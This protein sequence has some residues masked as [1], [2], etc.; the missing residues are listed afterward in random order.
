LSI[1]RLGNGESQ[2]PDPILDVQD[3]IHVEIIHNIIGYARNDELEIPIRRKFNRI[4]LAGHSLGSVISNVLNY[5][6]PWDADCTILT[7]FAPILPINEIGILV[8]GWLLPADLIDSRY[9]NLNPAYLEF[10]NRVDF[11]FL[12]YYPGQYYAGKLLNSP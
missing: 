9:S 6:Y 8:Q 4:I 12:F 10:S 2:R 1:D 7:G 3:P 11:D 5:K